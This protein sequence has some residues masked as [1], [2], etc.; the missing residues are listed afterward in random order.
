ME[1]KITE[2]KFRVVA[3]ADKLISLYVLFRN[4]SVRL[5]IFEKSQIFVEERVL[6]LICPSATRWLSHE[7]CFSRIM[8]VYEP[9]LV[10]LSQLYKDRG[11]S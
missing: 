1:H 11:E 8:E 3:D 10:A 7:E 6:K 2:S 9:T 5:N 4:S